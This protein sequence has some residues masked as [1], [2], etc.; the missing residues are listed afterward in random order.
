ML[1][2]LGP[3]VGFTW[4]HDRVREGLQ[5]VTGMGRTMTSWE[6]GS[7]AEARDIANRNLIALRN[8]GERE[9][10]SASASG[11]GGGPT[12]APVGGRVAA[13]GSAGAAIGRQAHR[14]EVGRRRWG[15]GTPAPPAAVAEPQQVEAAPEASAAAVLG[16]IRYES[17]ARA[18]SRC[19]P[20]RPGA[21][22]K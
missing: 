9:C 10:G 8:I 5:R 1:M 7:L 18:T 6:F 15:S 13:G 2:P 20:N 21:R 22:R 16:G 3:N 11:F 14:Q 4:A 17:R 19:R 12:S